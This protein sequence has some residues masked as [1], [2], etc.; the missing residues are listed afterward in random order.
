[1]TDKT[2]CELCGTMFRRKTPDVRVCSLHVTPEQLLAVFGMRHHQGAVKPGPKPHQDAIAA[3]DKRIVAQ[4]LE[5]NMSTHRLGL[6]H[7]LTGQRIRVILRKHIDAET[8]ARLQRKHTT[9][10]NH[11]RTA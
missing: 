8:R 6:L 3:R 7:N 11:R 9:A 2:P 1:M 10:N 5:G 4:Y